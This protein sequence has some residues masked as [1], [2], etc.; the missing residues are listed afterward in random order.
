MNVDG[1]GMREYTGNMKINAKVE[2]YKE[3]VKNVPICTKLSTSL[4]I[5]KS[6]KRLSTPIRVY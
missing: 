1:G 2:R 6:K 4:F 3:N 5:Y